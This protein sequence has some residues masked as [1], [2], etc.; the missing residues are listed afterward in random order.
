VERRGHVLV[1]VAAL[2]YPAATV[3]RPGVSPN[4]TMCVLNTQ[5]SPANEVR[6]TANTSVATGHA[7]VKVRNDGTIE[8]KT[9]V[10]NPANEVF[11]RA[12]IHGTATTTQNAGIVVDF[13]EG[14][15]P[16]TSLTGKTITFKGIARV[17]P[18]VTVIAAALCARPDLYYVNFHSTTE[19]GGAT[20][21]QLG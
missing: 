14:G 17:R 6:T 1:V 19:P 13:L 4:G 20:R 3:A 10:L 16:V 5:L 12:H 2:A 18:G 11:T 7:Q 15:V 21:G 9:F 8:F